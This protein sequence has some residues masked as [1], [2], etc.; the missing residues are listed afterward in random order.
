M[1]PWRREP[2]GEQDGQAGDGYEAEGTEQQ[3]AR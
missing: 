2:A 1:Q 3:A